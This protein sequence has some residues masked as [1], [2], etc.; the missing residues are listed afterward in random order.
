LFFSDSSCA[1]LD[2]SGLESCVVPPSVRCPGAN[3]TRR[4]G[5][6]KASSGGSCRPRPRPWSR[7]GTRKPSSFA[8]G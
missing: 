6:V 2:L 8:T 3:S 1:I 4:A 7:G 5:D